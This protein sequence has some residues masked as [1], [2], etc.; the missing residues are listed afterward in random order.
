MLAMDIFGCFLFVSCLASLAP[1]TANATD[2]DRLPDGRAVIVI[3]E[4]KFAFPEGG[5]LDF[6]YF[7]LATQEQAALREVLKSPDRNRANFE[8]MTDV[9]I[10]IYSAKRSGLLPGHHD[11]NELA[12]LGLAFHVG[13]NQRNCSAWNKAFERAR[14]E[15][16]KDQKL[17]D[18]WRESVTAGIS[19]VYV[20]DGSNE[21]RG[22]IQSLYCNDQQQCGSSICLASNISFIFKFSRVAHP[23]SQWVDLLETIDDSLAYIL[24]E[25]SDQKVNAR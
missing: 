1:E 6:V 12:D 19:K 15:D 4:H 20:R 7:N 23:K 11:R 10:T 21:G 16:P 22:G 17:E 13:E 24:P 8:R 9:N 18:G 3:K 14:A 2:W 25:R 5:D